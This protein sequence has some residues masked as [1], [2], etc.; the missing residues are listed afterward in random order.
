MLSK[1]SQIVFSMLADEFAAHRKVFLFTFFGHA[2]EVLIVDLY[3][4]TATISIYIFKWMEIS[5]TY[6]PHA[7]ES[8][9]RYV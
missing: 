3:V 8:V 1:F 6:V 7:V 9:T 5:S 2:R 4:P